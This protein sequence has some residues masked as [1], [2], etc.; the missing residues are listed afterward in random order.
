MQQTNKTRYLI[1]LLIILIGCIEEYIPNIESSE[2]SKYVVSGL[3]TDQE[4]YQEVCISRS[5]PLYDTNLVPVNDC[6]VKLVDNDGHSFNYIESN[7]GTYKVWMSKNDLKIGSSYKIEITTPSGTKIESEFEEM[8]ECPDIDSVYYLRKDLPTNNPDVFTEGIQLYIDLDAVNSTTRNF[9]FDLEETWEYTATYPLTWYYDGTLHQISPPDYSNF[10][11]WKTED[12][13]DVFILNT[14]DLD[15][16]KFKMLPL[17]F[18]DNQTS[19][20]SIK[21]SLL[22]KQYSLTE[23]CFLF[24]DQVKI[25]NFNSASLYDAQPFTVQGNLNNLTNPDQKILGYFQVSAIKTKRI[26]ISTIQDLNL[27]FYTYCASLPVERGFE[28]YTPADYPVYA[29]KVSGMYYEVNKGC[30]FCQR[31]GGINTKPDFWP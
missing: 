2:S 21:Y 26:F 23:K 22:V 18:V 29:I 12:I 17:N 1:F 31:F 16:N 30:V 20:L 27:D 25:N 28:E 4:G 8:Y 24:W 14:G 11:C 7:N 13:K 15:I 6:I 5:S 3:L 9:K 19:R 10:T